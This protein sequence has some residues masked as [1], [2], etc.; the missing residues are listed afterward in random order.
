MRD[1][2]LPKIALSKVAPLGYIVY[3]M[4]SA[5]SL[6]SWEGKGGFRSSLYIIYGIF[7]GIIGR[8]NL[9]L[10][11]FCGGGEPDSIS[12]LL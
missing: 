4:E 3:N 7:T 2:T 5:S 6:H 9:D 1:L 10:W 12:M 11:T 8:T